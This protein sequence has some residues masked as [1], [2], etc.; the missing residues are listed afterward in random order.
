MKKIN[1]KISFILFIIIF[2]ALMKINASEENEKTIITGNEIQIINGGEKVIYSGNSKAVKG[3]NVLK[4][5]KIIQDRSTK[6]LD[7]QGSVDFSMYTQ[8]KEQVVGKSENAEF[9]NKTGK[10]R[11]WNGRPKMKYFTKTSTGPVELEAENI[12]FDQKKNEIFAKGNVIVISS[13]ATAYSPQALFKQ[14]DKQIYLTGDK[15]QPRVIF[16][17]NDKK[18]DYYAD[19][20]TVYTDK[21]KMYFDNNVSGKIFLPDN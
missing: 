5:D 17:D 18:G 10:G 15:V 6:M 2:F 14:R 3:D 4:A 16:I 1:F 19:K 21:K 7:A 20:I 8:D 11:L 13:S 9:N 12:D